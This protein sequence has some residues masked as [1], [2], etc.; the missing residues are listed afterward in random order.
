MTRH[1][2]LTFAIA[3]I[4]VAAVC[5][6]FLIIW[7]HQRSNAVASSAPVV[8]LE[9]FMQAAF[10]HGYFEKVNK[11]TT[12]L[13]DAPTS[14]PSKSDSAELLNEALHDP[15]FRIRVRAMAVLPYISDREKAINALIACVH[16][17]DPKSSG[18]GNVPL[19][20]TSYLAAMSATRAI[21]DVKDW[22]AYLKRK[23][24]YD[25][26]MRK[27][28]LKKSS[29]DLAQLMHDATTRPTS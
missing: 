11:I 12:L 18:G 19:Y 5:T 1:R 2:K 21:P 13:L 17:R 3:L 7:P 24:P 6:I 4:A 16:D 27:M 20:A 8:S 15:D 23:P 25:E 28:I 26:K 9:A 14:R 10:P 22:V 29:A